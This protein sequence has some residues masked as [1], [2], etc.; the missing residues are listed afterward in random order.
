MAI[1]YPRASSQGFL[2]LYL[3]SKFM[4]HML[5]R[6][7]TYGFSTQG[8]SSC[9]LLSTSSSLAALFPHSLWL[10]SPRLCSPG[11]SPSSTLGPLL[12]HASKPASSRPNTR[13]PAYLFSLSTLA[14]APLH[15][16]LSC[17]FQ[18]LPIGLSAILVKIASCLCKVIPLSN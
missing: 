13:T 12:S 16:P 10:S 1:P 5:Y 8:T 18:A 15:L 11:V 14:K 2:F 7:S 3:A 6:P 4:A 9:A 17:T